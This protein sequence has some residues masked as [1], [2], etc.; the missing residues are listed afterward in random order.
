M[1][2]IGKINA[3]HSLTTR[4]GHDKIHVQNLEKNESDNADI[5]EFFHVYSQFFNVDI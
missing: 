3:P 1:E 2:K 5:E 4:H